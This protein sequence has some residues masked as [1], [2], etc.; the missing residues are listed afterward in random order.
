[1]P[2]IDFGAFPLWLNLT[3]FAIA[4]AIV[5]VAGSR[6]T[7]Y[8]DIIADR[9]G[10]GEAFVGLVL[11]AVATSLPE[12]GRTIT[13]SSIG[14]A[15]LAVDSLFGGIVLQTA[16]LA[17]ADLFV[18]RRSLTYFAPRPVLLLQG[19]TVVLLLALA[20]AGMAAGEF[21]EVLGVGA[22]VFLLLGLYVYSIY[23]LKNY[24]T[25]EQWRPLH[26]PDELKE[27]TVPEV[28][29]GGEQTKKALR[30]VFLYFGL[31][32]LVIFIAG[33]VL[34]QVGDVLAGQTGLGASFVGA[35]L[36]ALAGALPEIST[37]I[38]AVRLGA[39]SMAIA[40]IFGTNALLVALL[41]LADAFYLPGPILES[42]TSASIFAAAM[43]VVATAVYL[44]GLIERRTSTIFRMGW[45]SLVVL[46]IYAI[47]LVVLFLLR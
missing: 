36:L 40:N 2:G 32:S 30:R 21:L 37:S 41:F 28:R 18:T 13:A 34:A 16:V 1:V 33:V 42:V 46:I 25:R 47:T 7:I 45:D 10:L 39:Y 22:W 44:M 31:S 8:A 6:L 20:L 12:I 17:V 14:N 26:L 15:A 38:A 11:L 27:E 9:T 29:A 23:A 19:A 3:V 35:T 24:E 5:W 4:A 43:G